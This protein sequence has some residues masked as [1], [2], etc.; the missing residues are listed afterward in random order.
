MPNTPA[1]SFLSQPHNNLSRKSL[2]KFV[3]ASSSQRRLDLLAQIGVTPTLIDPADID[4]TPFKAELPKAYALRM[5]Q[6]KLTTTAKRHQNACVLAAD[7]VVA[8]GRR[9]L[10]K[11]DNENAARNCL[12]LLS[13]RRHSVITAIAMMRPNRHTHVKSVISHV[14]FRCLSESDIQ[15][16]LTSNEWDGK[17]GGYAIQGLAARYIRK[18]SGSYSN[19]VGLPLF[20]V[21]GWLDGL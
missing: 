21:A 17:A 3:L 11:A 19:V 12:K 8:C 14:T 7:T 10:P 9:I 15:T 18:I 20:E 16:Y 2:D 5:A 13:G 4:E 6:E 1:A